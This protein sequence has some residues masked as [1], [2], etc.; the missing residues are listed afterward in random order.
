M[1]RLRTRT[2]CVGSVYRDGKLIVGGQLT[3]HKCLSVQ[4]RGVGMPL[5]PCQFE[6]EKDMW[7]GS[8]TSASQGK[9]LGMAG[10]G[11]VGGK[12]WLVT[13]SV[14]ERRPRIAGYEW[15]MCDVCRL[16]RPCSRAGAWAEVEG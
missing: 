11:L 7:A 14:A 1:T 5:Q 8:R 9:R 16:H 2:I 13:R 15:A 4:R 10:L 12:G 3:S 6:T